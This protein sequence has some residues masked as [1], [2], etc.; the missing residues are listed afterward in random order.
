MPFFPHLICRYVIIG[1]SDEEQCYHSHQHL[2]S[3]VLLYRREQRH[4]RKTE[5]QSYT[6]THTHTHTHHV[7]DTSIQSNFIV[8]AAHTVLVINRVCA[9]SLG[10]ESI[11]LV[12]IA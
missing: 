3:K 12:L 4:V 10:L 8:Q 1:L 7:A 6:H 5:Y 9:C 11:T 2:Q